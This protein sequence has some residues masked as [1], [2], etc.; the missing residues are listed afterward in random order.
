MGRIQWKFIKVHI[1]RTH[2]DTNHAGSTAVG[3]FC[4]A[5]HPSSVD[6]ELWERSWGD[7]DDGCG[8]E[9]SGR[10][11]VSSHGKQ[12]LLS[13]SCHTLVL[14]KSDQIGSS[15]SRCPLAEPWGLFGTLDGG[16]YELNSSGRYHQACCFL[17]LFSSLLRFPES[18]KTTSVLSLECLLTC[19]TAYST[20]VKSLTDV[21]ISLHLLL[22]TSGWHL[23]CLKDGLNIFDMSFKNHPRSCYSQ[24]VCSFQPRVPK[25]GSDE[26]G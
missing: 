9:I 18:C 7:S 1:L 22:Y 4:V 13:Y 24:G 10:Q 19:I 26:M 14:V 23:A 25:R 20:H 8:D 11:A 17:D 5:L 12:W 2:K 6:L 21:D 16:S 15:R 3:G